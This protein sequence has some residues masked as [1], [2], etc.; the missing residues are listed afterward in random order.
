MNQQIKLGPCS[1]GGVRA[2]NRNDRMQEQKNEGGKEAPKL[3]H[4]FSAIHALPSQTPNPGWLLPATRLACP[5]PVS[6]AVTCS[7]AFPAGE[8]NRWELQP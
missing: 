2:K 7:E 6:G 5:A 4:T 8:E 1:P 3:F